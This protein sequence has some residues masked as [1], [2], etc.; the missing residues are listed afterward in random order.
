[1]MTAILNYYLR[2]RQAE[3]GKQFLLFLLNYIRPEHLGQRQRVFSRLHPADSFGNP[4]QILAHVQNSLLSVEHIGI[5][6]ELVSNF[7]T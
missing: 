7:T 1:M 3:K 6:N 2:E 4:G 5:M